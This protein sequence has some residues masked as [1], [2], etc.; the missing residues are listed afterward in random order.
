MQLDIKHDYM[1]NGKKKMC[2]FSEKHVKEGK[3]D[4]AGNYQCYQFEL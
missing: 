2:L 3:T 4:D 1:Q